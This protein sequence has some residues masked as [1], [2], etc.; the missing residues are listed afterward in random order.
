MRYPPCPFLRTMIHQSI[1]VTIK[2]SVNPPEHSTIYSNTH[3]SDRNRLPQHRM[4]SAVVVIK[5]Y[6]QGV[7]S[8][9]QASPYTPTENL[10]WR[11]LVL[12]EGSKLITE[13]HFFLPFNGP[14]L[15]H[16]NPTGFCRFGSMLSMIIPSN[17]SSMI[18]PLRIFCFPNGSKRC[19]GSRHL[20]RA[21]RS[22]RRLSEFLHCSTGE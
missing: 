21:L 1:A 10:R 17:G 8:W 20:Y 18:Y 9:C 16:C 15:C 22:Y 19:M 11:L 5:S 12:I 4:Q 7:S 2:T 13:T 6:V 3:K 14:Q